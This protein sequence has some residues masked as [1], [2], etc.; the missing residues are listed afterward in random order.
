MQQLSGEKE[1][2]NV[3]IET[4]K[5]ELIASHAETERVSSQLDV[6]RSQV[7]QE[8]AQ[9]S[10]QRERELRETQM[11]LERC[12]IERGEW[13]RSALEEQT[14]SEELRSTVEELRRETELVAAARS[15][16]AAELEK[17]RQKSENLQ[18]VLQDFQAGA[19]SQRYTKTLLDVRIAK[20]H[21]LREAVKNLNS[22]V[23]QTIQ[24]LAEY[25]H[26]AHTAE[27]GQ[28]FV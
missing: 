9:E 4:L 8:S 1:D 7:L 20:D 28:T 21:E 27:V 2:L 6:M 26:R 15:R 3:T 23:L 18:S 17:E 11:E 10:L 16:D 25:K 22:Q 19:F 13:E 14:V 24:S 5:A 12:R